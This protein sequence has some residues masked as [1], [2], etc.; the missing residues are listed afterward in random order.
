MRQL[1]VVWLM[2]LFVGI[3]V[4]VFWPGRKKELEDHGRIPLDDEAADSDQREK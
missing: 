1:W 2:L 3:A 4:W